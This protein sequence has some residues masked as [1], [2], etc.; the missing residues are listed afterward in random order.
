M[1]NRKVIGMG[2]RKVIIAPAM[3]AVLPG[4]DVEGILLWIFNYHF[5]LR[6]DSPE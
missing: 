2:N 6:E 5:T 3:A 4:L 1:G